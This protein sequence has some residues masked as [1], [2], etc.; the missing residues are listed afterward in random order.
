MSVGPVGS[1]GG[2]LSRCVFEQCQGSF[3]D[4]CDS[5]TNQ[6][7]SRI[8][9]LIASKALS[10][11]STRTKEA[12]NEASKPSESYAKKE[13]PAIDTGESQAVSA[14]P[15]Q[16]QRN[17][18]RG[19]GRGAKNLAALKARASTSPHPQSSMEENLD[20]TAPAG[21]NAS[22]RSINVEAGGSE[23]SNAGH[24][25]QGG[26]SAGDEANENPSPGSPANGAGRRG[27]GFGVKN[28]AAMRARSIKKTEPVSEK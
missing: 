17:A 24:S 22:G 9:Q 15:A 20:G 3:H 21:M 7:L 4:L 2:S 6:G 12:R 27:K 16:S 5:M 28:L 26:T 25:G 1:L 18:I 14:T 8:G 10:A 19:L 13:S 23:S 11:V